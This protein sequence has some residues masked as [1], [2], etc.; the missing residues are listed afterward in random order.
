MSRNLLL[1]LVAV[2]AVLAWLAW[3]GARSLDAWRVRADRAEA[4]IGRLEALADGATLQAAHWQTIADSIHAQRD[5]LVITRWRTVTD[6]AFVGADTTLAACQA[7]LNGL[8]TLCR[9]ALDS[10]GAEL[11]DSRHEADSYRAGMGALGTANGALRTA[12]DSLHALL[13]AVP[14]ARPWYLPRL[15]AGVGCAGGQGFGCG[16]MAGLAFTF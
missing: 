4:E 11:T 5:T 8:R 16:L 14:A 12:N 10:V 3:R 7:A 6:T 15:V 2:G 13:R 9:V 1:W